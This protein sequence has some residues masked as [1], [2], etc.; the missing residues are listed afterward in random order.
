MDDF[1]EAL[2]FHLK[3][4]GRTYPWLVERVAEI[5]GRPPLDPSTVTRWIVG[6]Y[7]PQPAVTFAIEKALG[8]GPGTLSRSLGYLPTDAAEFVTVP[9]AVE[10]DPQLT[11]TGRRILL[12]VYQEFIDDGGDGS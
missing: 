7:V 1:G 3:D 5:T 12:K 11:V 6:D 4:Q 8:L 2:R 9:A 10:A